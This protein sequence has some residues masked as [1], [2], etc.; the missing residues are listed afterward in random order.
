MRNLRGRY[1]WCYNK[2]NND[3][4][5]IIKLDIRAFEG[6]IYMCN[7]CLILSELFDVASKNPIENYSPVIA[8]IKEMTNQ[9]RVKLFAGDCPLDEVDIHLSEETHYTIKHYF[10]C[11][12]CGRYFAIGACIRG[13][14]SYKSMNKLT[15][16]FDNTLWGR[17]GVYFEQN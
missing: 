11:T 1:T 16:D 10:K 5:V 3:F 17:Y 12:Y 6:R 7:K 2:G 9:N 8:L 13:A 14:P 15:N 4:L